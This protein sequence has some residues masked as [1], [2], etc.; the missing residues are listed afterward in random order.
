MRLDNGP[1]LQGGL[2]AAFTEA[3]GTAAWQIG[4]FNTAYFLL[5]AERASIA[6]GREN[7]LAGY[8]DY[9]AAMER[10]QRVLIAITPTAAG[11]NRAG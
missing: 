6:Q 7:Q 9:R 1:L 5:P 11:P 8:N 4:L 10:E 3:S 2:G